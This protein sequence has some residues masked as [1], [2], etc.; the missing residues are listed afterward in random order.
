MSNDHPKIQLI[1]IHKNFDSKPV[2]NNITIDIHS[3]ESFVVI[4]GSGSGKS[5]MLKC[6]LGLIR[7]D[8]GQIII[9]GQNIFELTT[10]N[11]EQIMKKF[12][13][14]FQ[15]SALFDSM[16]VLENVAF[17][18][19][20]GL[21]MNRK[22]AYDKAIEKLYQVGLNI[23][24]A[25]LSPAELSGGMQKRVAIAR[26]IVAEPDILFFDEPT[27]GLDP[28]MADIINDLIIKCVRELKATAIS[29]THD[30]HSARKISDR[31]AMLYNNR[32]IWIG[33]TNEVDSVNNAYV[34]Q[35]I[36]GLANGP[37]KMEL[38]R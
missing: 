25:K 9:N 34:N 33:K 24:I 31:I 10:H 30:M 14:L 22:K 19:I 15:N 18:L 38:R 2:L 6:I 17:G 11:R 26:A 20:H 23:N 12:G 37:I 7:P 3:Y 21:Q 27:S 8:Y 29:I 36:N 1:N 5:V 32:L 35:F 16:S 13:V 28:I 4:G